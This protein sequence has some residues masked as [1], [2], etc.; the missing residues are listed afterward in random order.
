MAETKKKFRC[1]C[2]FC[3]RIRKWHAIKPTLSK[4]AF[5]FVHGLMLALEY[6][7]TDADYHNSILQGHWL[8]SEYKP[9]DV[10]ET[11]REVIVKVGGKV[12]AKYLFAK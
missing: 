4:K 10:G 2:A 6:E 8:Q 9:E 7:E 11:G 1:S 3:K 12:K 5:D